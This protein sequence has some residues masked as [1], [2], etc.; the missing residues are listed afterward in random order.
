MLNRSVL[1]VWPK[2]PFLDWAAKL[3]DSGLVPDADDEGTAYLIPNFESDKEA[4]EILEEIYPEV[5]ENE[6]WD[7]HTDESAWPQNRDF[8]MFRQWFEIELQSVV[9]DLC[10]DAI[11]DDDDDEA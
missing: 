4:W 1:I 10:D 9:K 2:Q 8:E 11:Y 7:W 5:F 6:L 3:D